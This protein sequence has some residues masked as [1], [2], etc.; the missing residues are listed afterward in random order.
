M[1]VD[2]VFRLDVPGSKL[3]KMDLIETKETQKHQLG[4]NRS[5]NKAPRSH[6]AVRFRDSKQ[7]DGTGHQGDG[8]QQFPFRRGHLQTTGRM[9]FAAWQ[10]ALGSSLST[11]VSV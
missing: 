5:E 11:L 10:E 2:E 7:T 1:N 3:S 8:H 6:Y 9:A 4:T